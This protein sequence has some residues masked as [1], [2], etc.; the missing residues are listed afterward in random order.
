MPH[1]QQDAFALW[2]NHEANYTD[3]LREITREAY[4]A[5]LKE[6]RDHCYSDTEEWINDTYEELKNDS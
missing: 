1:H 3:D 2:W 5:G 6:M 4:L